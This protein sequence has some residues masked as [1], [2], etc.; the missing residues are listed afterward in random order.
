MTKRAVIKNQTAISEY[1]EGDV[2]LLGLFGGARVSLYRI[3]NVRDGKSGREVDFVPVVRRSVE[4]E[5]GIWSHIV[6]VES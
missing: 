4:V 2:I 5:P 6:E 1:N 3:E